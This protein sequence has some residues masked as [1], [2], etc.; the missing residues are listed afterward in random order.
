[1]NMEKDLISLN[2]NELMEINGG[3]FAYDVGR[4]IRFIGISISTP[5]V[6]AVGVIVAIADS[7]K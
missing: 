2:E 1:M 5:A 6:P 4:T 3:S 7:K